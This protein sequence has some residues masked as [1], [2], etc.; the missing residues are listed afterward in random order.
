MKLY[1]KKTIPAALLLNTIFLLVFSMHAA[2]EKGTPNSTPS[3]TPRTPTS[4]T[5]PDSMSDLAKCIEYS[6]QET[7]E[8][9]KKLRAEIRFRGEQQILDSY[10]AHKSKQS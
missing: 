1:A 4:P 8:H 3:S 5:P 10:L 9:R 2:Q 7:R 6:A